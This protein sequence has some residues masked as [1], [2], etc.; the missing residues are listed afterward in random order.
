MLLPP[1]LITI[2][3][4][5][6]FVVCKIERTFCVTSSLIVFC[7]VFVSKCECILTSYVTPLQECIQHI[8]NAAK[9]VPGFKKDL[10]VEHSKKWTILPLVRKNCQVWTRF[11]HYPW[12]PWGLSRRSGRWPSSCSSSSR[13]GRPWG[14]GGTPPGTTPGARRRTTCWLCRAARRTSTWTGRVYRRL[15]FQ[16]VRAAYMEQKEHIGSVY[17]VVKAGATSFPDG[18]IR[19]SNLNFT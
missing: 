17:T 9:C 10:K 8:L 2:I 14:G 7:T 18:F 1:A 15:C 16:R 6:K 4:Q 12:Q 3:S 11:Y 5:N 13:R 19:K